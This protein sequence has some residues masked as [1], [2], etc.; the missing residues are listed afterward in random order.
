[1]QS[2]S[3][4]PPPNNLTTYISKQKPE[5]VAINLSLVLEYESYQCNFTLAFVHRLR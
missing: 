5:F 2:T 4:T 3:L 1:M